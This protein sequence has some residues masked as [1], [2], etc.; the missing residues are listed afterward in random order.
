MYFLLYISV[1]R[2]KLLYTLVTKNVLFSYS[3]VENIIL[4]TI[5]LTINI[6]INICNI[7]TFVI[8]CHWNSHQEPHKFFYR[9]V[10]TLVPPN[11]V[12]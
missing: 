11:D 6:E 7:Q 12:T 10:V 5:I 3:L 8:Y 9:R 4:L 1:F 2:L